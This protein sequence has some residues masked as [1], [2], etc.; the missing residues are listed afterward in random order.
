MSGFSKRERFNM[1]ANLPR[2][3]RAR[4]NNR[5]KRL[6][7]LANKS[8]AWHKTSFHRNS[9]K[10]WMHGCHNSSTT[11]KIQFV[12][13]NEKIKPTLSWP[14]LELQTQLSSTA[15]HSS[16]VTNS[17]DTSFVSAERFPDIDAYIYI[18]YIYIHIHILLGCGCGLL[19]LYIWSKYISEG[20]SVLQISCVN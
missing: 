4:V 20:G 13:N 5:K 12:H 8:S 3:S 6:V 15:K 11:G 17:H 2:I 18:Y 9:I 19:I 16:L 14:S 7:I 1:P 10:T